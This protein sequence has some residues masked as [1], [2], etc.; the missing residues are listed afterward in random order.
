SAAFFSLALY[1]YQSEKVFVPLIV[2]LLLI[3][4]GKYIVSHVS[5]KIIGVSILTGFVI[6]LPFLFSVLAN[7]DTL[8]RARGVSVF[9]HDYP[10]IQ[11]A[12]VRTAENRANQDYVGLV[13]DNARVE[14]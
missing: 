11:Q 12:Y 1:L 2:L 7:P 9:A 13:V 3:L 6:A 5:K 10:Q 4:F 14:Y 8:S